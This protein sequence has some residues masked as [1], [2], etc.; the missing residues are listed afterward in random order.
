MAE[1]V[2][3]G[4]KNDQLGL[5][6]FLHVLC[7]AILSSLLLAFTGIEH[8]SNQKAGGKVTVVSLMGQ[9]LKAGNSFQKL[10]TGVG[11]KIK[12]V[13]LK[14]MGSDSIE[15]LQSVIGTEPL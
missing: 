11:Q 2:P 3:K 4:F 14:S 15:S 10:F 9:P 1:N 13:R 8:T 7:A 6:K 12:G 5:N